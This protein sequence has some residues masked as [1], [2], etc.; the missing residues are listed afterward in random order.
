MD[1]K[2]PKEVKDILNKFEKAGYKIYLVGGATRDLLMKREVND[3]DFTTDAKPDEILELFSEGYYDNKFGTV[4]IPI[5]KQVFEVTTMRKEGLYKDSRHPVEVS[6]T[7]QIREDLARRD[8]TINAMAMDSKGNII[9]PFNG[10]IDLN[11]KIIRA[12]G[13][14]GKR[15]QEDALR[16][17]RAIRIAT[18]LDFDIENITLKAIQKNANLIGDIA[19]DRIRDEL[20]KLLES[21]NPYIGI[22][23]LREAGILKIILP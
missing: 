23:K 17:M 2:L 15:F 21:M 18:Q 1:F 14:S 11:K 12:V 8:F 5:G 20:F 9:D 16:L 19:S 22:V 3:W 10:A 7:N 4:G 6:W 13:D